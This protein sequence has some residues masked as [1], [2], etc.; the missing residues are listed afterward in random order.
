MGPVTSA[1]GPG[2][3]MVF[4]LVWINLGLT[5]DSMT[6]GAGSSVHF[7]CIAAY[8]GMPLGQRLA[9]SEKPVGAG[10]GKPTVGTGIGV[11]QIQAVGDA[12]QPVRVIAAA[13][14]RMVK[15]LAGHAGV[16]DFAR[17]LIFKF[18]QAAFSAAVA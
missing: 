12:L 2:D 7:A 13:P 10:S 9:F 1:I 6:H 16:V 17:V 3:D 11:A 18:V 15:E 4:Q 14:C 5:D 8:Q